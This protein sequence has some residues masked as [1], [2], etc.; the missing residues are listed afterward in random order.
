MDA[1]QGRCRERSGWFNQLTAGAI[2]CAAFF[3]VQNLRAGSATWLASPTSNLWTDASNWTPMTVPNGDSDV[4]TFGSSATTGISISAPTVVNAI[5]FNPGASAFTITSNAGVSLTISGAGM[6]NS[7]GVT[8]RLVAFATSTT[9][10][11]IN[12]TGS[13]SAGSLVGF[14]N[15][16]VI[17]FNDTATAGEATFYNVGGSGSG[18]LGGLLQ[19]QGNA[20]AESAVITGAASPRAVGG[21]GTEFSGSGSAGAARIFL[22]GGAVAG[23]SGGLANFLNDSTANKSI[24]TV[25]GGAQSGAAGARVSFMDSATAGSS[26]ITIKGGA[27]SGA[28]GGAVLFAATS[29]A[30]AS[31]I[32]ANGGFGGGLGGELSLNGDS[33]GGTAALTISGNASLDISNHN[34]PGVTAGSL[35]G[36]G[37]V[38]LGGKSLTVGANN[39][40]T[41]FSGV[42]ADGNRQGGGGGIGGSFAKGGTGTMTL[43][44]ANTYTGSTGVYGGKLIISGSIKSPV[45]VHKGGSLGGAGSTLG[46]TVQGGG[47]VA[48][49]DPSALTI[50]G[51]YDQ[52]SGGILHL[53][54]GGNQTGQLD[55][56]VV[57]GKATIETGA[58]LE[59]N[60]TGGYAPKT[61]DKITLISAKSVTGVFASVNITGLEF[62]FRYS[63]AP[64]GAGHLQL[65][66]INDAK[67]FAALLNLST[68][69]NVLTGED[70]LIGGFIITGT[71]PKTVLL[72]G[73]GPSLGALK[74]PIMGALSDPVLELHEPDGKVITND[75]WADTQKA[76]ILAT[77]IAPTFGKES[78]ILATL[79][80]GAYTAILYGNNNKTGIALI[81]AYDLDTAS[82]STLANISTRGFVSTG[83]LVM[84][85]GFIVGGS[86]VEV[87]LRGLGP[88]LA[89]R[90]V[91]HPLADTTLEMHNG[92]GD[93]IAS[94]DDWKE[95]QETAIEATGLAP[96]DDR[97]SAI[98]RTVFAGN[99]TVI[100]RGKNDR[101]GVGLVEVYN[102]N[103]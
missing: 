12:F 7:S 71:E 90:G 96:S 85:G 40:N 20:T 55:Q 17:N 24:I 65:T 57:T 37:E 89:E 14:T 1:S 56:L 64:D 46:V 79:A 73:I 8:Q 47:E 49:G 11:M 29:S 80:P 41:T 94:N 23:G 44:G 52:M 35:A 28:E 36:S 63:L 69:L 39:T 100:L 101:K 53:N 92:N 43:S 59:L 18:G 15:Y 62:G 45:V 50:N 70:V 27:V 34:S 75:N 42:M 32:T 2:F 30:G 9:D 31:T 84:I 87:L 83:D 86:P 76:E 16:G 91:Q 74:P 22:Q 26:H 10:G 99:Y 19:F 48:P 81:E 88:E 54:I 77:G 72:R 98:L 13:A 97:E 38:F 66:A 82:A 61:G 51:D 6:Q 21:G 68:R 103:Q 4:A 78:A 33:D 58:I 5:D 93:I 60:F 3:L 95:T 67:P 102:L 25:S